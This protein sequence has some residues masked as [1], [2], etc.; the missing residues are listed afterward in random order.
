MVSSAQWIFQQEADISFQHNDEMKLDS[1]FSQLQANMTI[2]LEGCNAYCGLWDVSTSPRIGTTLRSDSDVD[3]SSLFE[4][5]P[6]PSRNTTPHLILPDLE[7][8]LSSA[9]KILD[10]ILRQ[11]HHL[12]RYYRHLSQHYCDLVLISHNPGSGTS[13]GVD[14]I[15]RYK[16]IIEDLMANIESLT[17][18]FVTG[19]REMIL[20]IGCSLIS[21]H[22]PLGHK[23][24]SRYTFDDLFHR[25]SSH[26]SLIQ[27]GR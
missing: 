15:E 13:I 23:Q 16:S 4:R 27:G 18:T 6:L 22:P 25:L 8:D 10:L 9:A 11:V 19:W 3:H 12:G 5:R 2:V 20:I 26:L 1:Y 17:K 7:A 24:P 21:S 14:G